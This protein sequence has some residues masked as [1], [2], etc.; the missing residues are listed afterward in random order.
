MGTKTKEANAFACRKYAETLN[1]RLHHII[2]GARGSAKRRGHSFDLTFEELK[3]AWEK[4]EGKCYYTGKEMSTQTH[5]FEL[6]S[7][8]RLDCSKSYTPS[9]IVFVCWGVNKMRSD[10]PMDDFVRLCREV[11]THLDYF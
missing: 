8:E 7:L 2:R 6:M 4:Q 5:S 3:A 1:G 10:I 9:N 11:S